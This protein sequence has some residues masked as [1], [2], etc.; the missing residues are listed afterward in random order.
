[1][2]VTAGA[3][4]LSARRPVNYKCNVELDGRYGHFTLTRSKFIGSEP[5]SVVSADNKQSGGRQ[6]SRAVAV[7]SAEHRTDNQ[8]VR[9]KR[10]S[11]CGRAAEEQFYEPG[12]AH[13]HRTKSSDAY[14]ITRPHAWW[15]NAPAQSRGR[16]SRID[17]AVL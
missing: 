2:A 13:G 5:G 11:G 4:L 12:G 8:L 6:I 15:A 7:C 1:M 16:A 14:R 9:R 17:G 3:I 10:P